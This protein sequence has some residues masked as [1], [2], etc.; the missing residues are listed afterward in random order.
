MTK[1]KSPSVTIRDVAR[2]AGVSVATVSRYLNHNAHV[3]DE[4]ASRLERVMD[5][6]DFVPHATARNLATH[7]TRTIGLLF[8]YMH[9][10]FFAPLLNGVETVTNESGFDLLISSH[11][12]PQPRRWFPPPIGPHNTDG[13]LVFADSMDD[14]GL[15]RL[16]RNDFPLV[17]IHRSSPEGLNLPCVT[18]ENKAASFKIVEHLITVHHRRRIVYLYGYQEDS[19]WRQQGYQQALDAYHIPLEPALLVPG[20]FDRQVSYKSIRELLLNGIEFDGV[21]AG[22]DEAAVGVLTAL[23]ES[24]LNVPEDVSVV[25]FDDV[26]MAPFL[27]PPLTTVRA[28]T[29]EVGTL[30]ARQLVK[31]IHGEPIE[32]LILLPTEMVTRRSCGC[33]QEPVYP[34]PV[35]SKAVVLV[36]QRLRR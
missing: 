16:A 9:G 22:D 36:D 17:L 23:Q 6:L 32:D 21:F 18:V 2:Q 34:N 33:V 28:P 3:S 26:H 30:A 31:L 25:G 4:V 13:L 11:H 19:K 5:A 10:D 1:T 7:K 29:E 8:T 27:T 15:R 35:T 12:H 14:D 24:G 20:E